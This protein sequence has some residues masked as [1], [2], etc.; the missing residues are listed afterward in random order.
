MTT[1]LIG[2]RGTGKSS[3]LARM[4]EYARG[5]GIFFDLDVEIEKNEHQSVSEIFEKSGETYFR[6]LE[7]KYFEQLVE[8]KAQEKDIFIAVGGGFDV[9]SIPKSMHVLWLQRHSDQFGRIF[10]DRPSLNPD[11]NPLDEFH[12]RQKVR[13]A[14]Y[15]QSA[16]EE[17]LIPEG[18][19]SPTDVEKQILFG[20]INAIDGCLTLLPQVFASEDRWA[21]FVEKR[22]KWGVQYFEIR[23]DLL[24]E[25]QIGRVIRDIPKDRILWARRTQQISKYFNPDQVGLVDWDRDL[26]EGVSLNPSS[27]VSVHSFREG[28]TLEQV[29]EFFSS[30]RDS[31]CHYKLAVEIKN[32]A[33]LAQGHYWQIENPEQCSFLPRSP[34]G[35][36]RWYRLWRGNDQKIN[37]WREGDG[38]ALDQPTLFEWLSRQNKVGESFAALLGDPIQHSYTPI[39]QEPFFEKTKHNVF[40]IKVTEDQWSSALSILKKWGLFAAA[41]TSPLKRKAYLEC[42]RISPRAQILE[43]VNTLYYKDNEGWIG[44]NTD[45]DGLKA[46]ALEAE[47]KVPLTNE[48]AIAVWGGGGTLAL[49]KNQWPKAQYFSIQKGEVREGDLAD[50]W[51]PQWVVWAAGLWGQVGTKVPNEL[52]RPELIIDLNYRMDSGGRYYA[53]KVGA[54]YISGETMFRVQASEQQKFWSSQ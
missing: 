12:T 11:L 31:G 3:L 49:M 52:W 22:L 37:F 26:L 27:M 36:W 19:E 14:N 34:S 50:D 40:P 18:L 45:I 51:R 42:K 54:K 30:L 35:D 17:Y 44:E 28:E 32:F 53:K 15:R 41:V 7:K 47:K 2:A 29:F 5:R 20:P 6:Q 4:K 10:L 46:L 13:I 21:Y 25:T 48:S 8:S 1:V 24:T 39:E 9:Q 16:W 33:E 43:A 23:D 38:S